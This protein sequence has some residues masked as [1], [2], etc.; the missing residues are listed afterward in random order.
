ME[1]CTLLGSP[2]DV[3]ENCSKTAAHSESARRLRDRAKFYEGVRQALTRSVSELVVR[4]SRGST[5]E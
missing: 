5:D 3:L 2:A 1:Q 4:R